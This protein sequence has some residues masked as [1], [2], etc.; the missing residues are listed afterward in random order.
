M[1]E[2]QSKRA[3]S[4][5]AFITGLVLV[6]LW[7]LYDCTLAVDPALSGIDVLYLIGFGAVFTMFVVQAVNNSLDESTRLSPGELTIIYAM[8]AVAIPWGILIRAALEAPVKRIIFAG[9]T[10]QNLSGE[11]LRSMWATKS[12]D[13]IEL[14][15]MGGKMPWE[16]P[17]DEWAKPIFYWSAIL[18]SFQVFAISV[19]LFFRRIFIDEEKLPFPLATVGQNIIEYK[20]ATSEDASAR[21]L[22]AS[23]RIAF[24][25]GLLICAPAVSGIT[26]DSTPD[27]TMESSYY[28]TTTGL[29]RGLSVRLSW[30]PFV[31]CF[32][33]F[34]PVDVLFTVMVFHVGL[35]ILLP[36]VCQWM[37]IPGPAIDSYML[38][39]LG[40]GGLIGLAFWTVF[41]NRANI[42][43]RIKSAFGGRGEDESGEP[44]SFR[45]ILAMMALSF[46]A[47][48]LLFLWGIGDITHDLGRHVLSILLVVFILATMLVSIM[49]LSG[50]QGWLYHSPW[51]F[52]MTMTYVHGRYMT[53]P[54]PLMNTPASYLTISHL[55]HFGPYHNVFGPHL[56]VLNS[57]KVARLTG[58]KSRDVLK[59]VSITLLIVLVVAIPLYLILIHY[60]GFDRI[61]TS[62]RWFNG[63]WNYE[64]PMG[65]IAYNHRSSIF[66]R[67]HPLVAI[68]IGVGIIG[69]VMYMRRER[70]GFPLSPV[71]LVMAGMGRSYF[72]HYG[73]SVIWFPMMIVLIVKHVIYRWFGVR[74]F[75]ERVVPVVLFGMMGLMT[76]QFIYRLI[77]ASMGRGFLRPY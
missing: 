73:T 10:R 23:V 55:F 57:L 69:F 25:L 63:F 75:R 4:G 38:N 22:R 74:F 27:I 17:W 77:L 71:G 56:H 26:P 72:G 66:N 64:Q 61:R 6:L 48:L 5:R 60:Y 44:A 36:A 16:I 35:S 68:P 40:M 31:L 2:L 59:A 37:G 41:F 62:D 33:M 53:N 46:V 70:V 54:T 13:A 34:F 7:L 50:E 8:V 18:L 39:I 42:L 21:K 45:V 20:P 28:G 9:G 49:R 43:A 19:V 3:F 24:L 67:I 29:I 14:F 47:F 52:G 65:N 58:T 1:A 12:R 76:A 15:R 51:W 32:L 30:D 11:W